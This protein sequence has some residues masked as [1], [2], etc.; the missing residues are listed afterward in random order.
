MD[1]FIPQIW[2][3]ALE[4]NLLIRLGYWKHSYWFETPP[5]VKLIKTRNTRAR[6]RRSL[7]ARRGRRLNGPLRPE[8][9]NMQSD[10]RGPGPVHPYTRTPRNVVRYAVIVVRADLPDP[11]LIISDYWPDF[12]EDVYVKSRM[13]VLQV[14][15]PLGRGYFG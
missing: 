3:Q 9:G 8:R 11:Q 7:K 2:T 5:R 1:F 12:V 6:R 14:F 10:I 13:S 15:C 4:R